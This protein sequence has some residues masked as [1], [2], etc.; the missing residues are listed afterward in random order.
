MTESEVSFDDVRR[1][2]EGGSGYFVD[3]IKE[4]IL[5]EFYQ[6]FKNIFMKV[7]VG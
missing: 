2:I 7:V 6:K 4:L 3:G 1:M 5:C